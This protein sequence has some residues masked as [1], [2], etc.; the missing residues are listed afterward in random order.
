MLNNNNKKNFLAVS[1]ATALISLSYSA[2]SIAEI[3]AKGGVFLYGD[4]I[5]VGINK[6]GAFGSDE[7]SALAPYHNRSELLGFISDPS[8]QNFTG[9]FDGDFFIPGTMEAGWGVR[10]NDTDYHNTRNYQQSIANK[11]TGSFGKVKDF[12]TTQ[13]VVWNGNIENKLGVRQNFSIYKKG[14]TAIVDIDLN[15]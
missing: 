1:I 14:L 2:N 9:T 15:P 7:L 8:G 6:H 4:N 13:E 10:F 5:Q 3:N 12:V 11:I